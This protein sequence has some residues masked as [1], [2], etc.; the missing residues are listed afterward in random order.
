[1]SHIQKF[2]PELSGGRCAKVRHRLQSPCRDCPGL[3]LR[4]ACSQR[5]TAQHES[6]AGCS[7]V[8]SFVSLHF[9]PIVFP[10]LDRKTGEL[11]SHSA[12]SSTWDLGIRWRVPTALRSSARMPTGSLKSGSLS[13][14]ASQVQP[15]SKAPSKENDIAQQTSF[16]VASRSNRIE[17]SMTLP[18]SLSCSPISRKAV[19]G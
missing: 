2:E 9:L 13:Q 6:A 16:H 15:R 14:S 3:A 8:S 18:R 7:T 5:S 4:G 11:A 1:M 12:I 19:L 17:F 10:V